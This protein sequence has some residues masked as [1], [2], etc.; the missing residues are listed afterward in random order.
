MLA[1]PAE[2]T[3]LA[4]PKLDDD[5]LRQLDRLASTHVYD[6]GEF[7][8]RAGQSD[9]DLFVVKSGQID[10]LNPADD[11]RLIVTHGPGEFAGDIDLLTRRPV[12]VNAVARGETSGGKTVLLRVPGVQLREVLNTIPRLGEKLITAF[13]V[14]REQCSAAGCWG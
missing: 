12:I 1:D 3:D 10:I 2:V 7:V 11:D 9:V 6:D 13:Q 8:L 5:D 4:F 14:R